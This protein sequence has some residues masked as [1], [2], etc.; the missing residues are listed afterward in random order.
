MDRQD[1]DNQ[2]VSKL[3]NQSDKVYAAIIYALEMA[4]DSYGGMV[5]EFESENPN[6]KSIEY[7]EGKMQA[8]KAM[9]KY[10]KNNTLC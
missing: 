7:H 8:Y 10:L 1:S 4:L 9:A 5:L 6:H 3:T 2:E